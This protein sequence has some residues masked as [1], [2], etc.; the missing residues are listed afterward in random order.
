MTT[1]LV[2][3]GT[4]FLGR[5]LLERLLQR[6]EAQVSVLVRSASLG[7]LQAIAAQ[8]DGGDRVRPVVGDLSA[9]GLGLTAADRELLQGVDHVVHLAA[10]Y[11]M[12]ASD[13]RNREVNVEGTRRVV[14]L[15]AA[16][17]AGR[18]HHVSSVAVAGEHPGRF[19]EEMFDEGQVLPSPYHRT[20]FEAERIVREQ[21]R[22][23]WRVYRPAVVVGDSRTGEMDKV[24]GPYYLFPVLAGIGDVP[25]VSTLPLVAPDLGATN[26]VPVDYVADAM[27]AL[28]HADG[29]DGRAFHLVHPRPQRLLGVY[30]DLAA[31]AGAP[32]IRLG[33]D[34][35]IF[36][37]AAFGLSLAGRVPGVLGARDLLLSRLGIPPEVLPHMTFA[38]EFAAVATRRELKRLGVAAPPELSTYAQR[39]WDYWASHLDPYRARRRRAGGA[40]AGRTVAVTGASSGIGREVALKVAE[41]GGVPLLLARRTEELEK[42]RAE[43]EE[44][45]GRASVY[46][47]DLT[48]ADSIDACVKAMLEDHDG[49]DMLV[50]NAGRSIRRSIQ[51]SYDRIHDFERTMSLNY[52]GPVRLLLA[53]LPSMTARKFGHVV[54]V[55]SIGVQANPP[56]FSA[57]VASKAA[58]DAFSRVVS[59]ELIGDG[60]TFTNIHMPLVRTPMI[61]PT[62]IYDAFPTLTPDQAA[63]M[64]VRALEEQPKHVGTRLGTTAVVA[65]ALAPKVVDALL[66]TAYHVFPDSVAAGGSD[67]KPTEAAPDALTRGASVMVRLLPGVHW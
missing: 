1:Y 11:D 47:V 37:P 16:V 14:E 6:P 48:D 46:S 57:Y 27:D 51:L 56:R 63:D 61:A 45:G 43:I 28:L 25:A 20:K 41:R 19:T 34:K 53:L 66:H 32:R 33:L 50:N 7:R 23:P 31:A 21:A 29:L 55:S 39:L 40:L 8:L 44:R 64:V 15:A 54:N 9:D 52:F 4:G 67:R 60:V 42:V 58:L 10:L 59:S 5:N 24:D 36:A 17:G 13:D 49:V 30:N 22:M 26:V 62:K 3:G 2:T 35:R 38:S 65:Y 12:T 18:F